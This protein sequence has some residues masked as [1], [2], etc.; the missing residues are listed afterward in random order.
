MVTTPASQSQEWL[1]GV[2]GE[3]GHPGY[4]ESSLNESPLSCHCH[5]H[6]R[7]NE[8]GRASPTAER[9]ARA[10]AFRMQNGVGGGANEGPVLCLLPTCP[11]WCSG[12]WKANPTRP[13]PDLVPP[14]RAK[15]GATKLVCQGCQW[16]LDPPPHAHPEGAAPLRSF[17]TPCLDLMLLLA[18]AQPLH[19]E[20]QWQA[21]QSAWFK[22]G[23][24]VPCVWSIWRGHPTPALPAHSSPPPLRC[25]HP[26]AGAGL[27]GLGDHLQEVLNSQ[28]K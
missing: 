10:R 25:L 4:S 26:C 6:L 18:L 27:Q 19:C 14:L 21:A 17:Q 23:A 1:G 28:C 7:V 3:P 12:A 5:W 8:F 15:A 16:H 22:P 13:R 2:Q 9:W 24:F 11:G 20:G